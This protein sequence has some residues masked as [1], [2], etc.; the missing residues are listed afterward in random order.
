[1]TREELI[2]GLNF[3]DNTEASPVIEF[4]ILDQPVP[5]DAGIELNIYKGRMHEDLPKEFKKAFYPNIKK[6][7]VSKQY[8]LLVYDPSLTPDRSVVWQYESHN[9][10]FFNIV[11]GKLENDLPYYDSSVLPYSDIWAVWIRIVLNEN[12]LYLIKKITPSKVLTTDWKLA[13][14][15][16][17]N[18]FKN[19][20]DNVLTIDGAFDVLS[21]KGVLIFKNKNNF[22]KALLY[23]DVKQQVA[24]ET[25]EEINA[26]D[27]I[28]NFEE[29]RGM[30]SDDKHSINKLNKLKE[31]EYFKHKT[32][33]DYKKII[34]DYNVPVGIDEANKK[35]RIEKKAQAKYLIKVLNDD[36]V[37]SELTGNKYAANSKEDI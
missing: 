25:L 32:F 24:N 35:F 11:L 28:E 27:I 10:S 1:M 22:E 37:K 3:L 21:I 29:L 6:N 17:H 9:I 34:M 14:V 33:E 31:K 2:A 4:F 7:L 18:T 30:L 13:L 5:A 15:F 12:S 8:D 19:L 16:S 20:N 36:Y 23:E 26:I